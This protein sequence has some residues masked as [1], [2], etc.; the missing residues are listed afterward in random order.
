MQKF[1][2]MANR[3]NIIDDIPRESGGTQVGPG[4]HAVGY[5]SLRTERLNG[6]LVLTLCD[7]K[8]QIGAMA[9]MSEKIDPG[10]YLFPENIVYTLLG[11]LHLSGLDYANPEY[12]PPGLEAALAGESGKDGSAIPV[13]KLL[14]AFRI[15]IIGEDLGGTS[16][17]RAVHLYCNN[18]GKKNLFGPGRVDVYRYDG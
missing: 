18:S 17:Y 13:R 7:P 2:L 1:D 8:R 9:H 10:Q 12:Q 14:N 6:G 11:C 3:F 15:P 5:G 16:G 4:Q